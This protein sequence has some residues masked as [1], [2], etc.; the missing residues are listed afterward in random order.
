[1][2]TY[3][4]RPGRLDDLEQAVRMY[5]LTSQK[6]T[7]ADEWTVES[8]VTSWTGPLI[9]IE[10]DTRVAVTPDGEILGVVEL[11]NGAP[12]Y[13]RNHIWARVHPDY[14]DQG[15]GT[16]LMQWAEERAYEKLPLAEPDAR[17]T[18]TCGTWGINTAATS[19]FKG[20]G[21]ELE[22]Y[23]V[24]MVREMVELPPLSALPEGLTLRPIQIPD[25][26][27]EFHRVD[28]EAESDHWGYVER[29]FDDSFAEFMH[30]IE[31]GDSDPAL[32]FVAMDGAHM[33][34]ISMCE[35]KASSDPLAGYVAS[36]GVRG[37]FRQRG[38]GMAL[39]LYSFR[40]LY[41]RGQRKVQLNVD[42]ANLTGALRLYE[43][44]GMHPI[45]QFDL[46]EKVLRDG[47]DM[48]TRE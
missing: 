9:N 29:P 2:T 4:L 25:E 48:M 36:L 46:Y 5:N 17:V 34:G 18:L 7:G 6:M 21:Y 37:T 13:V 23:Y 20:V 19:L 14:E 15:V 33:A 1:M 28:M 31:E 41:K 42:A 11:W 38:I 43:R 12:P 16:A 35:L 22:R 45:R 32:W 39:L 10:E 44:A 40:E 24:T 3:S 26:Y 8:R 47:R 27:E 30:E